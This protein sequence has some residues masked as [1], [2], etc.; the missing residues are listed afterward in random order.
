MK[1][2]IFA[3]GLLVLVAALACNLSLPEGSNAPSIA[4]TGT[5]TPYD[6]PAPPSA[7]MAGLAPPAAPTSN[8]QPSDLPFYIDCN[9]IDP[10]RQADCDAYIAAT[11][12]RVYPLLREFTGVSLSSCYDAIY[13]TIL[14]GNPRPGAVGIADYNRISYSQAA[15]VDWTPLF[16]THEIIHTIAFCTGALD[17]HV[18][19]QPFENELHRRLT[20]QD[21]PGGGRES[22]VQLMESNLQVIRANDP[23]LLASECMGYLTNLVV[24]MYY[25]QGIEAIKRLYRSTIPVTTPAPG[26][27]PAPYEDRFKPL[28]NTLE[29]DFH[30]QID[31]PQ[32]G[33]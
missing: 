29:R 18:F 20:G 23:S 22:A 33:Y 1:N 24:V 27:T 9:A 19:H 17:G 10:S 31:V 15:S 5:P 32:C 8:L 28:A 14:P 30:Y 12:D 25:D 7:T 4:E 2:N 6:A 11:R 16:D 26:A 3:I 21:M 13:Y